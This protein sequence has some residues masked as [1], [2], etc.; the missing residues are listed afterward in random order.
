VKH[1][2]SEVI[3]GCQSI[4]DVL[5]SIELLAIRLACFVILIKKLGSFIVGQ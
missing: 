4:Q 5:P 3:S 1:L 2:L